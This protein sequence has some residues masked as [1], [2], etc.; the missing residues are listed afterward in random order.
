MGGLESKIVNTLELTPNQRV[1]RQ[2]IC[3]YPVPR[4]TIQESHE[5]DARALGSE[6]GVTA[7]IVIL[8]VIEFA[9]FM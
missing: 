9:S 6:I 5:C 3:M 4:A 7:N 1:G 2:I 8:R